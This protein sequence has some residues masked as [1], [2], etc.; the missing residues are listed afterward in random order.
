MY[1]CTL[2][3]RIRALHVVKRLV[4]FEF[5]LIGTVT[6]EKDE[7]PRHGTTV[8]VLSRLKPAFVKDGTGTVTAGN[9]SVP[10]R[11]TATTPSVSSPVAKHN[12]AVS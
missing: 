2:V 1:R 7:F 6:V 3:G 10:L 8:E 9:A 12:Q 11:R 4:S 5:L